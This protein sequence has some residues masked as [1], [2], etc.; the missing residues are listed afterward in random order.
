MSSR[1]AVHSDPIRVEVSEL[2]YDQANFAINGLDQ[3]MANSLRRVMLAEVPT[4]AID[5]VSIEEN[6]SAL[7]D[8]FI[9]HRLGLVPLDSRLADR[10]QYS[11]DCSC[12]TSCPNCTV[13]YSLDVTGADEGVTEV[14]HLDIQA[15]GGAGQP[16][17]VP[18]WDRSLSPE[19]NRLSAV[20]VV[21]LRK[22]Q[23]LRVK[24]EAK[25]GIAKMH[26]KY[27]PTGTVAMRY[28]TVIAIDR[29]IEY[30]T[31]VADRKAIV[32]S[33]PRRVFELDETDHIVVARADECTLT[34][35]CLVK[36]KALGKK[37]LI[38]IEQNMDR[39]IFEVEGTKARPASEVVTV[40][41]SVLV[42]KFQTLLADLEDWERE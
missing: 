8:E 1:R 13:K 17:P 32:Y 28:E 20:S 12:A 7:F 2:T 29:D 6:T 31:L 37:G 10:F 19:E 25:K 3:S 34:D 33:C 26:A 23:R 18:L 42:N 41:A 16:L 24:M 15:E 30:E 22:N 27:N 21:K 5:I 14:T 4:L 36:A 40:A 35:E 9:A 38:A 11:R 39:A